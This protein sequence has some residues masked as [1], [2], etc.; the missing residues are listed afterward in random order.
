MRWRQPV[1]RII[2][3]ILAWFGGNLAWS[4]LASI[5][6]GGLVSTLVSPLTGLHGTRLVLFGLFLGFLIVGLCLEGIRF[7]P[8]TPRD[9]LA[10]E[11]HRNLRMAVISIQSELEDAERELEEARA[12]GEY[13]MPHD[14]NNVFSTER[15]NG[16]SHQLATH[17]TTINAYKI[18]DA[19]YREIRRLNRRVSPRFP[20]AREEAARTILA[21]ESGDKNE[22][23]AVLNK[24]GEAITA[25]QEAEEN[26]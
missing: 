17:S 16:Y 26:L 12:N 8:T 24:V 13:R 2:G 1:A 18:A 22:I 9:Q 21:V 15:W 6:V 5:G 11:Q 14:A 3:A 7:L 25:F 19:A 4:Y 23:D 20:A 10:A